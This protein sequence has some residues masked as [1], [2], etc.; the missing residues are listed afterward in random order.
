MP[1]G[2]DERKAILAMDVILDVSSV[3]AGRVAATSDF[4]EAV[5]IVKRKGPDNW[6]NL[7]PLSDIDSRKFGDEIIQNMKMVQFDPDRRQSDQATAPG[8][9]DHYVLEGTITYAYDFKQGVA[10]LKGTVTLPFGFWVEFDTI[11]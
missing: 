5:A 9:R 8:P 7:D 6:P 3:P 2:S 1:K 11:R 4:D 10:Q